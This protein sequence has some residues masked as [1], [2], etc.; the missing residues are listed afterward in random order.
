MLLL[1]KGEFTQQGPFPLFEKVCTERSRREGPGRFW[2]GVTFHIR[3]TMKELLMTDPGFV[4]A[5]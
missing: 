2:M 4:A 3:F 5:L 1:L